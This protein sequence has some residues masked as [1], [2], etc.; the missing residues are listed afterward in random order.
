MIS[1]PYNYPSS[2]FE[3]IVEDGETYYFLAGYYLFGTFDVYDVMTKLYNNSGYSAYQ[4][5]I[6]NVRTA[7]GELV[8]HNTKGDE[9]GESH[10]L[11]L[12]C[13]IDSYSAYSTSETNFSIWRGMVKMS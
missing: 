5:Q 10:G 1:Y 7:L 11:A 8:E 9:A 12:Y 4:T 2:W 13:P 6:D 3:R